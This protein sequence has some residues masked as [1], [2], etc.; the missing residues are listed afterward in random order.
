MPVRGL[1]P[2]KVN[3]TLHVTGR[4]ADGYHLLDSLVAFADIGDLVTVAAGD[5]LVVTGPFAAGVPTDDGNLIRRALQLGGLR[6]AVTLEKRL[7]H[8][9]GLGGGS[10]DAATVLSLAGATLLIADLLSLGADVPVCATAR[11]ARM[12]GVGEDVV[13][14]VL[15]PL[16]AVLVNPCFAV[17]TPSV[18][19]ALDHVGNAGHG[20]VPP[21]SDT[22]AA[23]SWLAAQRN[24]LETAAMRVAPGIG[25]VLDAIRETGAQV[26]RMSGSGATCFGLYSTQ[27]AAGTAA[28]A[29]ERD[30]WWVRAC[31]LR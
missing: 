29:L 1:A 31:T 12:R 30:G 7:P 26:T 15:P 5:G 20:A 14:L 11:A 28:A 13:P 9:A 2:A 21:F 22:D 27:A 6:R 17:S 18:F 4:R 10:S 24:D 8:P 23:L 3:L 16:P 19:R 25:G